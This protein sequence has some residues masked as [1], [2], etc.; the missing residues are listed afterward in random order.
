MNLKIE[1]A[2]KVDVPAVIELM[3]EFAAYEKLADCLEITEEKLTGVLFGKDVFVNCLVARD[4]EKIIGYALFFPY[5]ASFRG[6]RGIYLE[7]IFIKPAYQGKLVGE[8]MLG[9]IARTGRKNGAL[10]MDFQVLEWNAP[11]VAFYRKHGA[12]MDATE[13]HFKFSDEAF[14]KLAE[15][16]KSPD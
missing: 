9:A 8:K 10:R 6:E 5:F 16:E 12:E 14:E 15:N 13:R 11:A 3:R 1:A 7:D 2:V 4:G